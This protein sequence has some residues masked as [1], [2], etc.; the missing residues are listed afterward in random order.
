MFQKPKGF[1]QD[2]TVLFDEGG[3]DSLILWASPGG[4]VY[5]VTQQ[6]REDHKV[7][8]EHTIYLLKEDL[9]RILQ[10]IE[11]RGSQEAQSVA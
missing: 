9:E 5:R 11:N 4:K 2:C 6:W 3:I 1:T 10:A 7:T 8:E